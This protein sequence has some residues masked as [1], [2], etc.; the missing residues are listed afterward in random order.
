MKQDVYQTITNHILDIMEQGT[1]PW[2]MPWYHANAMPLNVE[3]GKPYRGVNILS[4][5]CASLK[6]GYSIGYWGTFNQWK[7]KGA[8]VRKGE[9]ACPVVLY[10]PIEREET[11]QETGKREMVETFIAR[12]YWVFNADQVDG[13]EAPTVQST[14]TPETIQQAEVFFANTKA[15]LVYDGGR[16]FYSPLQDQ[17]T[18]PEKSCFIDTTHSTATE[19]YYSTLFHELTHWTGHDDRLNRNL[20]SR[21]GEDSR[22][23]EELIA[24]LGAAFL[25]AQLGVS[26]APR[27]DHAAYLAS[28]LKALKNDKH[29]VFTAASKASQAVEYLNDLQPENQRVAA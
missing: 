4:L 10:K 3:S 7:T 16:A 15:R 11:N 5:W 22:A 21:F 14:G 1:G 27:E 17:I 29:A 18:M 28:W 24:E 9:K 13:W 20:I 12:L 6:K 23:M 26:P 25:C 8:A 19:N 2:E